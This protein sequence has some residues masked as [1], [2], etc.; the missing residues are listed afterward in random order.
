ML[1][2]FSR[3]CA[4]GNLGPALSETTRPSRTFRYR[5]SSSTGI[6]LTIPPT[7]G[8]FGRGRSGNATLSPLQLSFPAPQC[9]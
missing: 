9:I 5:Y 3:Y 7:D 4:H 2:L 8:H 1:E 6:K